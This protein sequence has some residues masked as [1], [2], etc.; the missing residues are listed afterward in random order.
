MLKVW[1]GEKNLFFSGAYCSIEV[2]VINGHRL[3]LSILQDQCIAS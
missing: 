1:G 2:H 3:C